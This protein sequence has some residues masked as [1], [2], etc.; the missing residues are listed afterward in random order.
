MLNTLLSGH[1]ERRDCCPM[2]LI[3]HIFVRLLP[4][5]P[6]HAFVTWSG[7]FLSLQGYQQLRTGC[8]FFSSYKQTLSDPLFLEPQD[9]NIATTHSGTL[10]FIVQLQ[11]W[12]CVGMFCMRND[13][14]Y[15]LYEDTRS[16]VSDYSDNEILESNKDV[17]TT[18]SHKQ[19]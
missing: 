6:A 16:G 19:L 9:C 15:A 4:R 14:L 17:P 3:C 11:S 10:S 2:H 18:S 5:C 8:F 13:I 1:I 7:L 12:L